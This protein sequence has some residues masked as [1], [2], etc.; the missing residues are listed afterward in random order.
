MIRAIVLC[1]LSVNAIAQSNLPPMKSLRGHDTPAHQAAKRF[2][3]GVNIANDLEV[4]PNQR[5]SVPHTVRDLEEIRA[6]GF[7]H[8]RIPVGWQ[9]YC[10][11]GPNF[12]IDNKIFAKADYL[13][14]NATALGLNVIINIHNFDKF[15]S[16][17]EANAEWFYA[18]W[19]QVAAHY[20]RSP[21]S[22]AFELLNEPKDAATTV[23]VN[24]IYAEAIRQIRRTNPQRAIFVGPGKWNSPDELPNLRLPENDD[25]IIVT[26]HCYA[27]MFFTHQ[28]A[29]WVKGD[30]I[31]GIVFPGP[32]QVPLEIDP[33]RNLSSSY[34][35]L[36]RRYNTE[37]ADKNPS[38]PTAFR[39]QIK[40]AKAWSEKYGRPVHFGEFGAYNK[41][42]QTSRANYYRLFRESLDQA[43]IGWAIWD[44]KSGFNYWDRQN[45]KPLPGM[46]EALF[47][48]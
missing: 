22:V 36:L 44:W 2:R 5:W 25:N 7:D 8:I 16:A 35:D 31:T 38:S 43:G 32:P 17:P 42:D 48:N 28:G 33:S 39:S 21:S 6:Q 37:P 11:P 9:F 26:L 19:R 13:V 1:L 40:K 45:Q 30:E 4:P 46:S 14:T 34:R 23:R 12:E 10:G 3:R 20:A 15:T 18:I 29:S 41:A 24:P 47:G 27:P